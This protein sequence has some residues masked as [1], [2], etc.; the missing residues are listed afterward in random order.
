VEWWSAGAFSSIVLVRVLWRPKKTIRNDEHDNDWG[1]LRL[2][3]TL[4]LSGPGKELGIFLFEF[5][6]EQLSD[7]VEGREDV[8]AGGGNGFEALHTPL[9]VVQQVF[10]I[11]DWSY[12]R[13]VALI[14][15]Q[16]ERDLFEGQVLL[17]QVMFKIAKARNILLHFFPLGIGDENHTVN[18]S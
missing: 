17:L 1:R 9:P 12:T 2:I 16:N 18:A 6:K 15:L 10:K 14:E 8:H 5:V 4:L 11:I 3:L 13:N 7:C